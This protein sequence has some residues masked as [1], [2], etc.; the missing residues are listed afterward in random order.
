M[1]VTGIPSECHLYSKTPVVIRHQQFYAGYGPQKN[2]AVCRSQ[3]VSENNSSDDDP[4]KVCIHPPHRR[5][6]AYKYI[7]FPMSLGMLCDVS[8]LP[9][10]NHQTCYSGC[11]Q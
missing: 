10:V 4:G 2:L 1:D 6:L 11:P 7:H 3:P 5:M 8:S 9:P